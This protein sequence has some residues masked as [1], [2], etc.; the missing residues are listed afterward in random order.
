MHLDVVQ[1]R[2]YVFKGEP[3]QM[4]WPS[5]EMIRISLTT[6]WSLFILFK[7]SLVM[8]DGPESEASWISNSDILLASPAQFSKPTYPWLEQVHSI[9]I[10]ALN[11]PDHARDLLN[12]Q[13]TIGT[14][15]QSSYVKFLGPE[16][17]GPSA[18]HGPEVRQAVLKSIRLY[19]QKETKL[20]IF[21]AQLREG[22]RFKI[23]ESAASKHQV[24]IQNG[25]S[26][27]RYGLVLKDIKPSQSSMR[28]ASISMND[29]EVLKYAPKAE[30]TYEIA[31]IYPEAGAASYPAD[32]P[33]SRSIVQPSLWQRLPSLPS[34]KFSGRMAPRGLP[35]AG[36][37]LP[38]QSIFLEQ[39]QGYYQL[40]AQVSG[41]MK[42]EAVLHRFRIPLYGNTIYRQERNK[43]LR[44]VKTVFEN[45]Y[46]ND[47]GLSVNL[48][49]YHLENRY[50]LGL[51]S[52]QALHKFELYSYV[53][54]LALTGKKFW[55]EHRWE[56]RFTY[57]F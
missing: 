9:F 36:S 44:Y 50:Q 21:P 13:N 22:L 18:T 55:H 23:G 17:S 26:R 14:K 25:D 12:L 7:A 2:L 37:P 8:A 29:Y 15:A 45:I 57:S 47:K 38:P 27:M 40:E 53:P 11:S 34:F 24:G 3:P 16:P 20:N 39:S 46:S 5:R 52:Q 4:R 19:A 32:M 41:S 30:T 10:R 54:D 43:D 42:Q 33:F 48:E 31:E 35:T 51:L 49:R 1:R 28:L 6:L 56:S